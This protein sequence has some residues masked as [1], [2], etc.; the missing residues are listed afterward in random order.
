MSNLK[1]LMKTLNIRRKDLAFMTGRTERAVDQWVSG[2]RPLPRSTYLLLEAIKD[3]RIDEGWLAKRL[4]K[5][6]S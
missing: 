3:R 4:A 6:L 5:F 2:D 1:T